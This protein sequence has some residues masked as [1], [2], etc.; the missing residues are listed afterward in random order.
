MHSINPKHK[1]F[2]KPSYSKK[3]AQVYNFYTELAKGE[4]A[5]NWLDSFFS[6]AY[7]VKQVSM[8]QQSQGIDRIFVDRILKSE[9]LVE[10]KADFKSAKTGNCFLELASR[11]EN[12]KIISPAWWVK[13]KASHVIYLIPNKK[14]FIFPVS[15]IREKMI[16]WLLAYRAVKV[17]NE[18]WVSSGIILPSSELEL[19]S[20]NIINLEL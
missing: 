9:I 16:E 11:I 8:Q 5:E 3:D 12:D 4:K 17:Y 13:S 1:Y 19:I 15:A 6:Q 10:Y 2:E 7:E 18:S 20:G 14:I